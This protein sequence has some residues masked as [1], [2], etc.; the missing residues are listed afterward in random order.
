MDWKECNDKKFVKKIT[1]DGGLI[2]SL[3][4]SSDKKMKSNLRLELDETTA[5]TKIG[6]AYDSLREILE[7]LAIQN[8]FKIY[9]HDC[10]CGFLKEFLSKEELSKTF[11]KS[12]RIRNLIN[13]YGK[14]IPKE[15]A[16]VI[17]EE[18]LNLRKEILRLLK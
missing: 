1:V 9:N 6:L 15:E 7:A 4:T 16:K 11:D 12:R 10:F 13:Y 5:C 8:G 14:D 3:K 2:S 17:I 18:I